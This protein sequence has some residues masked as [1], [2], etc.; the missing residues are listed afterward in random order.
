MPVNNLIKCKR[1]LIQ[2]V[3]DTPEEYL[4]NLLAIVHLFKE[5]VTL[6]SAKKSFKQGWGE[7]K[8]GKTMP[9]SELA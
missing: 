1:V 4:P 6:S 7:A 8:E 3:K 9:V 5:S 2:E